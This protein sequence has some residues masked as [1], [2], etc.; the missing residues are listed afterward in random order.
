MKSV[1]NGVL[2]DYLYTN[3]GAGAFCMSLADFNN[4]IDGVSGN[5]WK[6]LS[7]FILSVVAYPFDLDDI[8]GELSYIN[9]LSLGGELWSQSYP[10]HFKN[11]YQSYKGAFLIAEYSFTNYADGVSLS[12]LDSNAFTKI[13][14]YL[15]YIG[16][17][18]VNASDVMEKTLKIYYAFD[19]M[20]GTVKAILE[21]TDSNSTT[22]VIDTVSATIGVSYEIT[23]D[24]SA[25]V[26]MKQ[27]INT[28]QGVAD[29]GTSV[30]TPMKSI[31]KKGT[32]VV[33]NFS[34]LADSISMVAT[35][36]NIPT[37][38]NDTSILGQ[39]TT[40]YLIIERPV[41]VDNDYDEYLG[42]PSGKNIT[43]SVLTG[44]TQIQSIHLENIDA[45]Y[46][47]LNEIENLLKSGVIF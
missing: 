47:E 21:V 30:T 45:T 27:A 9:L 42:K 39:P 2:S 23:A 36:K 28:V 6:D 4:L 34:S 46:T 31:I 3:K 5:M 14:V 26:K 24:N 11:F 20:K 37:A 40:P 22:Y 35:A 33:D 19:F 10:V 17:K 32:Q 43:L 25:R 7:G 44:Y 18:S 13:T 41:I 12:Y 38:G 15:P 1:N 16:F 29:L 8:V